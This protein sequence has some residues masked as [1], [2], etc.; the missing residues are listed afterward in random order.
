MGVMQLIAIAI[1]YIE[2]FFGSGNVHVLA[3]AL[4]VISVVSI[5][6]NLE[7][8]QKNSQ[9]KPISNLANQI[10]LLAG[11]SVCLFNLNS[12]YLGHFALFGSMMCGLKGYFIQEIERD[13]EEIPEVNKLV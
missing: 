3:I 12:L 4:S 10:A 7:A 6:I 9:F 5:D 8:L 11:V 13:E 2:S 1:V